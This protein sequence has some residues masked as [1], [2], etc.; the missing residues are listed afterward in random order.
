M[1]LFHA[2]VPVAYCDFVLLDA[3]WEHRVTVIRERLI[4]HNIEIVPAEVYSEKLE[5][6]ERFFEN[7]ENSKK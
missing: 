6:I 7:L 2:I 4:K 3:Q 1:D 5:G